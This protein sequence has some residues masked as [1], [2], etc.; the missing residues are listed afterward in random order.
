[1]T[2]LSEGASLE[3]DSLE[4]EYVSDDVN[5]DASSSGYTSSA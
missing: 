3:G 2:E 1:M 5:E 4:G